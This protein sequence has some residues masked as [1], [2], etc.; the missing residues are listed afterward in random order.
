VCVGGHTDWDGVC[1][2]DS[3]PVCVCVCV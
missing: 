2:C 1:V 3:V